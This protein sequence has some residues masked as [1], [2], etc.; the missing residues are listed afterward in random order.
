M[1][2]VPLWLGLGCF[3]FER[4]KL[5][6]FLE[7]LV[8]CLSLLVLLVY[9]VFNKLNNQPIILLQLFKSYILLIA[10]DPSR[11]LPIQF[12][13][14]LFL[15]LVKAPAREMVKPPRIIRD[16]DAVAYG[17]SLSL[18]TLQTL[19]TCYT[20]TMTFHLIREESLMVAM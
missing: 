15:F 13:L 7:L 6:L 8:E 4:L 5:G 19:H 18:H 12:L 3:G 1:E 10:F 11:T 20:I 9:L 17:L 2:G 16:L 14:T